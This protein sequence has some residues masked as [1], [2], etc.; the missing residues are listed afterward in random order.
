MDRITSVFHT[1]SSPAL[2]PNY[3]TFLGKSLYTGFYTDLSVPMLAIC[4]YDHSCINQELLLQVFLLFNEHI[5]PG[6]TVFISIHLLTTYTY[7]CL[8]FISNTYVYPQGVSHEAG[9]SQRST[10]RML[11]QSAPAPMHHSDSDPDDPIP[12]EQ[13]RSTPMS[14]TPSCGTP[15]P[16]PATG[17]ATAPAPA[18]APAPVARAG[19][20]GQ[21]GRRHRLTPPSHNTEV[22][23][24]LREVV[25]LLKEN[26]KVVKEMEDRRVHQKQEITNQLK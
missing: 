7:S 6:I 13:Q 19:T 2:G 9:G 8:I 23:K 5:S 16:M 20:S 15:I 25:D 4:K 1:K 17:P 14:A 3:K 11:Q 21:G 18:P 10:A 26:I 22:R 24:L 12:T